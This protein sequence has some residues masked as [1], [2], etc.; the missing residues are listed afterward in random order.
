MRRTKLLMIG[1]SLLASTGLALADDQT[2]PNAPAGGEAV[3]PPATGAPATAAAPAPGGWLQLNDR[4]LVLPAGKFEVHGGVPILNVTTTAGMPP[5]TSS[6]VFEGLSVGATYGVADKIEAGVDYSFPLHPN[7]D[8]TKGALALHGAFAAIHD[9]KMDL[10]VAAALALDLGGNSTNAQILLGAWFRYHVAPKISIFTGQIPI[11]TVLFPV[12]GAQLPPVG[13]QFD[14]GL[15][16]KQPIALGL[17]VGVGIQ[18]A[19]NVFVFAET[20]I[21][22]IYFSNGP[23]NSS[24]TFIFSDFIPLGVGAYF[25]ASDQ[26]DLGVV[27]ADDLKHAGDAYAITFGGRYYIK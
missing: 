7:G 10:A 14:I 25:A 19:P 17:P 8:V 5:V 2:D 26:L 20:E 22:N 6:S 4:P 15:N 16:N 21:A 27:F 12:A 11:P 13:Y 9:D 24:A 3:P 1:A 23:G 18:A